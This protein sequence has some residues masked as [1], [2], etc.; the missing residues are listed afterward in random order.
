MF[1]SSTT[2]G[3]FFS[4]PPPLMTTQLQYGQWA[5]NAR[6]SLYYEHSG[7]TPIRQHHSRRPSRAWWPGIVLALVYAYIGR[8]GAPTAK[9]A[10]GGRRCSSG[11]ALV[12]AN[13]RRHRQGG[14]GA[15]ASRWFWRLVAT[16]TFVCLLTSPGSSLFHAALERF[17]PMRQN[18]APPSKRS[19]G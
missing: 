15:A 1:H 10:R 5:A 2:E 3:S 8:L 16:A 9:G 13:P 12:G 6:Y 19:A 18:S 17:R 11:S 7:K 14:E 4:A